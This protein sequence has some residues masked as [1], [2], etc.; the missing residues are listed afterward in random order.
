VSYG[1]YTVIYQQHGV[2]YKLFKFF[3]GKDGSYYVTSPYHYENKAALLK[4]TRNYALNEENI[5]F[6][7]AIDFALAEDDECRIKLSHHPDGLV[8]FSGEGILSGKDSSG[9]ILGIGIMSWPLDRPVSGPAFSVTIRGVEQF[10]LANNI[11]ENSCVFKHDE[12][13]PMP[14]ANILIV[15]GHY[16][17]PLWRRFIQT[18][19]DGEKFIEIIH[20]NGAVLRLKV[21]LSTN[22][23]MRA[24]FFG[25]ECYTLY[26][27]EHF[28]GSFILSGSTGNLRRNEKGELLGDGI[29]CVYPLSEN[30]PIKRTLNYGKE[31]I[32]PKI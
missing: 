10:K 29:Y 24:G 18:R 5:P 25:L 21:L 8:Q 13:T 23:C 22:R 14:K 19:I 12:L 9:N 11:S 30:M 32:P 27:S 31:Y 20:P 17:P 15:E 6:E 26:E 28:S 2:N 16:F 1:K 4:M 7:D 3:Y